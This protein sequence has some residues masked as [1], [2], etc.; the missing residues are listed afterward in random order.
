MSEKQISIKIFAPKYWQDDKS[1]EFTQIEV[2]GQVYNFK[3]SFE[4]ENLLETIINVN[5][6]GKRSCELDYQFV[7]H[8]PGEFSCP[9]DPR[10]VK[11]NFKNIKNEL[12]LYFLNDCNLDKVIEENKT[13]A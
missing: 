7:Y 3:E 9:T 13:K 12:K 10:S 8:Y 1:F 11:I 6:I 2:N 4:D 5:L